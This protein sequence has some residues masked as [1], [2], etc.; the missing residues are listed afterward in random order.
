MAENPSSATSPLPTLVEPPALIF[1][2]SP[3]EKDRPQSVPS[4]VPVPAFLSTSPTGAGHDTSARETMVPGDG[5]GVWIAPQRGRGSQGDG[6]VAEAVVAGDAGGRGAGHAASTLYS[7]EDVLR[8]CLYGPR[9]NPLYS[10]PVWM[11]SLPDVMLRPQNSSIAAAPFSFSFCASPHM[12]R[13]RCG[14]HCLYHHRQRGGGEKSTNTNTTAANNFRSATPTSAS[15]SCGGATLLVSEGEDPIHPLV[16]APCW[17]RTPYPPLSSPHSSASRH[18]V[19]RII[20]EQARRHEQSVVQEKVN[21]MREN[22][23]AGMMLTHTM[24]SPRGGVEVAVGDKGSDG[25]ASSLP[26]PPCGDGPVEVVAYSQYIQDGSEGACGDENGKKEGGRG[27]AMRRTITASPWSRMGETDHDCTLGLACPLPPVGV[28][29]SGHRI[30]P[31][32]VVEEGG[33]VA[34]VVLE[35]RPGGIFPS[36]PRSERR[37]CRGR[38]SGRGGSQGWHG[39]REREKEGNRVGAGGAGGTAVLVR[40]LMEEVIAQRV[41]MSN[42]DQDDHHYYPSHQPQREEL[43]LV[44]EGECSAYPR[45]RNIGGAE[46]YSCP[47]SSSSPAPL[48]PHHCS[49]DTAALSSSSSICSSF[50]VPRCTILHRP[51]TVRTFRE[52]Q[53][54]EVIK[55][56]V[57]GS[58]QEAM[59]DLQIDPRYRPP[60]HFLRRQHRIRQG[61]PC[62]IRV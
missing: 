62:V 9:T 61:K 21:R 12:N 16:V 46:K 60:G 40:P 47:G 57:G 43:C 8:H 59:I 3:Q 48:P 25:G 4:E 52:W 28:Y 32:V 30:E 17:S 34:V 29:D 23:F 15:C 18:C 27:M 11:R 5:G 24:T 42:S 39:E 54:Q 13:T 35:S 14:S 6:K 26:R 7:M 49:N 55:R 38:N 53:R 56:Y 37:T 19:R 33:K 31:I 10:L 41:L 44:Q 36:P 20:Q 45:M 51:G 1:Q 22:L 2:N 58:A 50:S